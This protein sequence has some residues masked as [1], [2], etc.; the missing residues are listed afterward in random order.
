MYRSRR[1][2][3]TGTDGSE[4]RQQDAFLATCTGTKRR[5][6]TSQASLFLRGRFHLCCASVTESSERVKI[7]KN[8]TQALLSDK[9]N[10]STLWRN[11]IYQEM[12]YPEC[13]LM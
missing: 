13:M 10:G 2:C 12:K 7:P 5:R 6:E 8:V 4:M 1:S 11:A 3:I 9:E